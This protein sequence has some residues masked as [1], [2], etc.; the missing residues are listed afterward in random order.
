[1]N[2]KGYSISESVS[3]RHH[4]GMKLVLLLVSVFALGPV[5]AQPVIV[6]LKDRISGTP[7]E[8]A[9][10]IATPLQGSSEEKLLTD[11]R[12]EAA[13]Q[14]ALPVIVYVSCIGYRNFTD[15]L[16][17]GNSHTLS[18][19]PEFYQLDQVVVTGQFRPQSVDKSI[20]KIDVIDARQMQLKGANTMGDLLKNELSFQYRSEGVLG[21]FIRIRGL[22]GNM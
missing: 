16:F 7:V 4:C 9:Y 19:S 5:S 11:E 12:G 20:Y 18:L 6:Q 17:A 1:M 13:L 15:T 22:W 21:D 10:V 2:R 14:T 3:C 8:Y